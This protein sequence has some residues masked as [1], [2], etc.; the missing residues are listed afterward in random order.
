M[1][2]TV[3]ELV[4]AI[5]MLESQKPLIEE[6]RKQAPVM[7][8]GIDEVMFLN[9]NEFKETLEKW[10]KSN[11]EMNDLLNEAGYQ[12]ELITYKSKV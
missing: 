7:N 3:N 5:K 10:K 6:L 9:E 4:W 12:T 11:T 2:T 1:S 8:S